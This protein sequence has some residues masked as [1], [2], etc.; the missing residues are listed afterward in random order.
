[1]AETLAE[2]FAAA[3]SIGKILTNIFS[4]PSVNYFLHIIS[5]YN[6]GPFLWSCK[7]CKVFVI[8]ILCYIIIYWYIIYYL[9]VSPWC[10]G[11]HYCTT[12]LS[13]VWCQVL[14]IFKSWLRWA[15]D[16][17]WWRSLTMDPA[18]N[19]AK[20]FSSVNQKIMPKNDFI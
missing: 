15:G 6:P 13:K 7:T 8:N 11:Y 5:V 16:S 12:W 3:I 1:M 2:W 4:Y 19:K 18:G 10:S 17:R 9:L 14:R 20:R